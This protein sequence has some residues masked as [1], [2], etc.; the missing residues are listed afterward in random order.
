MPDIGISEINHVYFKHF[1]FMKKI[2]YIWEMGEDFGHLAK[3]SAIIEMMLLEQYQVIFIVKDLANIEFFNWATQVRCIQAP[4]FLSRTRSATPTDCF[5]DIL[6]DQGYQSE[7]KLRPLVK[8]WMELL[9]LLNPDM[10]FFDHA[11]TALLASNTMSIPRIILSNGFITPPAGS[12]AISLQPWHNTD[13]AKLIRSESQVINIINRVALDLGLNTIRHVS[14]LYAVDQVIISG[15]KVLDFY[16]SIR[17]NAI[18]LEPT[19]FANSNQKPKWKSSK[20]PKVFAYLKYRAKNTSEILD[21]LASLNV[22][23]VC[24]CDKI[25]STTQD[26]Y[27]D[28][29]IS[30]SDEILDANS[31]FSEADIIMC[32]AGSGM[33]NAALK[34]GLPMIL[35]PTQLE[36]IHTTRRLSAMDIAVGITRNDSASEIKLKIHS[37]LN[38]SIPTEKA[39]VFQLQQEQ[40]QELFSPEQA[41]RMCEKLFIE[42][43]E[44]T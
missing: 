32:H 36:Q 39:K 4:I 6:I 27:R 25:S 24:F 8:A 18:Y 11:P 2:V 30:I 16:Q 12:E 7:Q 23:A 19:T 14:D 1:R 37:F 3:A 34:H 13:A 41:W 10:I 43:R 29:S 33:T 31:I 42:Q 26:R 40:K 9:S 44:M 15:Y 20:G 38:N 5:A 21:A 17:S 22:N 28:T 35:I